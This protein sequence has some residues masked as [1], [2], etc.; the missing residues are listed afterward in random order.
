MVALAKTDVGSPVTQMNVRMAKDLHEAGSAALAE[1]GFNPSQAVR[2]LW[3]RAAMRGAD[4]A[5]VHA[6]LAGAQ[7]PAALNNAD[8]ARE[9]QAIVAEGMAAMGLSTA[10]WPATGFPSYDEVEHEARFEKL[11]GEGFVHG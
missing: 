6:L 8:R 1:I 3:E 11:V 4:L 7:K 10:Q 9:G 5:E 2:A